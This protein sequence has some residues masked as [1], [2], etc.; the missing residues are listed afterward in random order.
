M[1]LLGCVGR[2]NAASMPF[3]TAL[4]TPANNTMYREVTSTIDGTF[5]AWATTGVLQPT[6]A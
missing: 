5:S 6:T 3:L 2:D 1:K 4:N